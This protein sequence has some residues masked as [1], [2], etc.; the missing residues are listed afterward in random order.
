MSFVH[1][2]MTFPKEAKLLEGDY[3]ETTLKNFSVVRILRTEQ[4]KFY[5]RFIITKNFYF[6]KVGDLEIKSGNKS[7]YEKDAKQYKVSKTSGLYALEIYKNYLITLKEDG[8]TS[9]VF[10]NATTEFTRQ[11]AAQIKKMARCFYETY[12]GTKK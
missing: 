2:T 10:N 4:G 8:I 7:Y 1:D 9:L 6:D 3:L 12:F 5:L 11:D